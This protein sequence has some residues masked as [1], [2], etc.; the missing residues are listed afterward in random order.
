MY[1]WADRW[2]QRWVRLIQTLH[3]GF[4]LGW[5][6]AE[7]LA[8]VTTRSYEQSRLYNGSTHN[9]SGL[10]RWER[11]SLDRYFRPGSR[12]LVAGCGGGRE[13]IDLRQLGFHADGFDCTPSLVEKSRALLE[14]LGIPSSVMLSQPNDV[15]AEL[16]ASGLNLYDS[17]IVGWTAYTHI[18][19][20]VLR[21]AFLRKLRGLVPREAPMLISFWTSE[22]T[23]AEKGRVA[24]IANWVRAL[25]PSTM[26]LEEGDSVTQRGYHH[27]FT[28]AEIEAELK[29]GGFRMCHYSQ[30]DYAHAVGIAE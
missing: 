3:E 15:P 21:I 30:E 1:L 25:R 13:L 7:D 18:S 26:P 10:F 11:E 4:W 2:V 12:I 16:N 28:E 17:I 22:G 23:A 8:A 5:L 9:Q 27:H 24:R 6:D 20:S 14:E 29:A 19:S